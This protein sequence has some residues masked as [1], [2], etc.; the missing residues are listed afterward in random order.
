M[1]QGTQLYDLI[2]KDIFVLGP[3]MELVIRYLT[4]KKECPSKVR[5]CSSSDFRYQDI[6]WF[7]MTLAHL[8]LVIFLD[9]PPCE[10]VREV[11]I[12]PVVLCSFNFFQASRY[13]LKVIEGKMTELIDCYD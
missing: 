1:R 10:G 13:S 3:K 2:L 11:G 12:L 5:C 7:E 4:S 9:N 6:D 8:F